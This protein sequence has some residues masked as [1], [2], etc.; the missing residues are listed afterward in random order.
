MLYDFATVLFIMTLIAVVVGA[1]FKTH[2]D[3]VYNMPRPL[4]VE[5]FTV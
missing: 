3:A 2:N 1:M 4:P 5:R